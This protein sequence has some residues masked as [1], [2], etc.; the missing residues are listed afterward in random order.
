MQIK[1]C[2][3]LIIPEHGQVI[4]RNETKPGVPL[5]CKIGRLNRLRLMVRAAT[6][7]PIFFTGDLIY[8]L[9]ANGMDFANAWYAFNASSTNPSVKGYQE[10]RLLARRKTQ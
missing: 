5:F 10:V 8:P 3:S 7:L 9:E 2:S 1:T 4:G 6:N